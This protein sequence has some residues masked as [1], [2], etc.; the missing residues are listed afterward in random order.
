MPFWILI[1]ETAS[2]TAASIIVQIAQNADEALVV[3]FFVFALGS[4]LI[5]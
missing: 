5:D 2:A 4:G 1:I 3:D